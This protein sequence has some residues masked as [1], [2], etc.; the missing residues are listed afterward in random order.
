MVE[1]LCRQLRLI[2]AE[3]PIKFLGCLP[4]NICGC[5]FLR[6]G[7]DVDFAQIFVQLCQRH[8]NRRFHRIHID[9]R[10]PLPRDFACRTKLI[11]EHEYDQLRQHA[12]LRAKN[13]LKGAV[14]NVS[15]LHDLR[16][17]CFFISLLQK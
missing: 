8:L 9:R 11:A 16:N 2:R 5:F 10:Q 17:R 14:G 7:F 13:I 4:E 15:F 6:V 12:V 3:D 1:I